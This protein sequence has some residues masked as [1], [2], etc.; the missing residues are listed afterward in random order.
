MLSGLIGKKIGM[1]QIFLEDRRV[2]PVTTLEVGPCTV[3]Q[4]KTREKDGYESVQLGFGHTKPRKLKKTLAGHLTKIRQKPSVLQE[5][6]VDK[7]TDELKEGKEFRLTDVF[8]PGG[9]V[10]IVGIAKGKG[11]AGV[12]KRHGFH[13]GPKTHGQ[14]DRH[15]APG[16]IGG[17]TDP[18]RVFKGKRMAGRMG[19]QRVTV[20]GLEIIEIN[21][22][23]NQIKVKGAVPGYRG[24]I[25]T[26]MKEEHA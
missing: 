22:Q 5:F 1:S 26:V 12:V 20:K 10:Q 4:I 11:F 8:L 17:R 14:S 18:G 6:R 7:L 3:V 2:V 19:G 13:G 15:R 23:E 21:A 16:S 9:K 25:V 24:S